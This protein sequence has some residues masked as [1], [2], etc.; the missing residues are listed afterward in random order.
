[1]KNNIILKIL[2]SIPIILI[3]LYFIPFLGVC[4]IIFKLFVYGSKKSIITSVSLLIVGLLVLIPKVLSLTKINI[5][6]IPYLKDI[7]NSDMYNI[8]FIKYSKLLITIGI[9][10]LVITIILKLVVT[11]LSNKFNGKVGEYITQ[12]QKKEIEISRE[13]DMK[14]K[15]KQ[16]RAKNTSYVKCPYCGT[17]YDVSRNGFGRGNKCSYCCNEYKNSFA[18]HIEIELNLRLED[19][20]DFK[21]NTLNPYYIYKNSRH[22]VWIKCINLELNPINKLRKKDYHPSHAMYCYKFTSGRRCPYCTKRKGFVHKYDS[23][24]YLYPD[25]AKYWDYN[26]NDKSPFEVAPITADKYWFRC[27]NCNTTFKRSLSKINRSDEISRM[28]CVRC[29]KATS[30]LEESTMAFLDKNNIE[31][32]HQK[33][34]NDLIGL[35]GYKLSYD[36]YL[37]I[38]C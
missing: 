35:G 14:I 1:M 15:L 12:M 7:I 31:Y 13:N 9:I 22:K 18:Y 29:S 6:K 27:K 3:A 23:F 36:F 32:I 8:N 19:V 38:I 37:L 30:K 26:K 24:G 16:E 25:K 4:L 21:K 17:E 5:D 11:K 2:L 28:L 10:F 34:Y 20:W 33:K